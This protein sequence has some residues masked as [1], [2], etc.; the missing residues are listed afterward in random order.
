MSVCDLFGFPLLSFP[1][2]NILKRFVLNILNGLGVI[3]LSYVDFFILGAYEVHY[4]SMLGC[5]DSEWYAVA[6]CFAS[7]VRTMLEVYTAHSCAI[8]MS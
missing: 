3:Y 7:Y 2:S 1:L 5:V 8:S 4:V 6:L